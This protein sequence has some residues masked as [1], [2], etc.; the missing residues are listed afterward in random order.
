MWKL[1][2]ETCGWNCRLEIV[3]SLSTA[4]ETEGKPAVRVCWMC[5]VWR[6]VYRHFNSVT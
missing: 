6:N 5:S 1:K 4:L 3:I 2:T